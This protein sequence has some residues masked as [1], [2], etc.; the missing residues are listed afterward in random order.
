MTITRRIVLA[1]APAALAGC[2]LVPN[3]PSQ[4]ATDVQLVAAGVSAAAQQIAAIPGVAVSVVTKVQAD[5]LI[6]ANDAA[7]IATATG[8]VA[9]LAQQIAVAVQGIAD[10]V[11][12]M[13][14]ATSPFVPL[15]NAAISLLPTILAAAGV[16][17]AKLATA[18]YTPEQARLILRAAD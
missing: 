2:S 5:A 11:L 8:A 15:I 10:I 17:G 12:P 18:V 7:K 4:F 6:V 16:K 9:G 3:S 1:S 13:F 14:P